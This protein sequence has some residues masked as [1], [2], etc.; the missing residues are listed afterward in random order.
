MSRTAQLISVGTLLAG[1]AAII[2]AWL[3]LMAL[4]HSSGMLLSQDWSSLVVRLSTW[5][6]AAWGGWWSV[7]CLL[8]GSARLLAARGRRVP[9]VL[10]RVPRRALAA[11][12]IMLGATLTQ[13]APAVADHGRIAAASIGPTATHANSDGH[14]VSPAWPI[15]EEGQ[16][17]APGPQDADETTPFSTDLPA[18]RLPAGLGAPTRDEIEVRAGDTLWFIATR[19]LGPTATDQDISEEWQRWYR[20]NRDVIGADPSLLTPGQRLLPPA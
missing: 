16:N 8:A 17:T 7:C 5:A 11:T 12:G 14:P 20:S 4:P 2:V 10:G 9:H 13:V 19:H 1:P 3:S 6:L 18:R 15:P